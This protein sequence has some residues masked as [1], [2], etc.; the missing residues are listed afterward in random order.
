MNEKPF[1]VKGNIKLL[2]VS[3]RQMANVIGLSP[4]RVNQLIDE[5]IMI[6]DPSSPTSTNL[7]F[8]ESLW[9][10]ALSK[11]AATDE[12]VNFWAERSKHERAKR[13][14]A[15]LKLRQREGELYEAAQVENELT[16]IF[17]EF[18]TKLLTCGHKLA[19]V[20]EGKTA[21]Q[22]CDII[23]SEIIEILEELSE[24]VEDAQYKEKHG[25]EAEI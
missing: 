23:D 19:K 22:I 4:A 5:G 13:Q 18:R 25:A 10:Y 20:L 1:T 12:N 3:Q 2:A 15:E 11:S 6:R 14:L 24:N 8:S 7:M 21:A 17:T 9:N 16:E